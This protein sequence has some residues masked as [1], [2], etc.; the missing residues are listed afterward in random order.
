MRR[1]VVAVL[2]AALA[3]AL[4]ITLAGCGG[5]QPSAEEAAVGA[6]PEAAAPSA[7][8]SAVGAGIQP[9][10]D[11]SPTEAQAYEPFPTDPET[12][13]DS[14][15]TRLEA[16]QPML[17]YFYDSDQPT[18]KDQTTIVNSVLAD[19]RGLVDLVRFDIGKY[20]GTNG[21]EIQ[22]DERML[23]DPEADKAMK[24][25]GELGVS[26]TP[27]IIIVD[28]KGY[29][30]FRGSGFVDDSTLEQQILLIGE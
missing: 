12:V 30:L 5:D 26:F 25:A 14:V 20:A 18:T 28:E 10:E 3:I 4:A 29:T 9:P 7:P 13:P 17:V 16:S 22:V 11:A 6:E 21:E 8:V 19:Y 23:D 1:L 24:L 27:Y 2:V 15:L